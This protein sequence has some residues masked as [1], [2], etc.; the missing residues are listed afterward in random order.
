MLFIPLDLPSAPAKVGVLKETVPNIMMLY[1]N[2]KVM[3][4]SLDNDTDFYD[5]VIGVM[6]GAT[7]ASYL[8]I[9]WPDYLL[10]RRI[11]K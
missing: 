5:I 2:I 10:T 7:L 3:V 8:V 6:Q 11:R 1:K 9:I 4:Y